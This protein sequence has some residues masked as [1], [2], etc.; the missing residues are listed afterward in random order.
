MSS[1]ENN[2]S[3]EEFKKNIVSELTPFS[4]KEKIE[5]IVNEVFQ[6]TNINI[7]AHLKSIAKDDKEFAQ[8]RYQSFF[9]NLTEA[10]KNDIGAV[11]KIA[12]EKERLQ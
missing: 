7:D 2:K 12:N 5:K 11:E 8:K 1:F 3:Y 4:E 10:L 6:T 9:D